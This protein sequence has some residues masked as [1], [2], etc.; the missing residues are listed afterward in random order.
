MK[1]CVFVCL[2]CLFFIL[3]S[4][5]MATGVQ[6]AQ[7]ALPSLFFPEPE[8]E[9]DAVFDGMSILHDFVIQN[10]GTATLDVQK[11]SGG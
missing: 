8:Y 3:C 11:A 9:F 4:T 7:T 6:D 10:R 2:C 5:A 1:K